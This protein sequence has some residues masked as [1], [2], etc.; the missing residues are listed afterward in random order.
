[1]SESVPGRLYDEQAVTSLGV[2]DQFA[3]LAD[4]ASIAALVS[5]RTVYSIKEIED[6][7]TRPT[8]VILFRLVKHF[9]APTSLKRLLSVGVV[10]GNIQSITKIPMTRFQECLGRRSGRS[11]WRIHRL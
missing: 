10:A 7:A 1:V 5:R 9:P 4:A 11:K 3:V 6:M 8:K 2:V